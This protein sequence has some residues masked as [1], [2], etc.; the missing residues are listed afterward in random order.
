MGMEWYRLPIVVVSA[1]IMYLVFLV[2][3]R[4]FGARIL[5]VTSGFD[6]LVFIMLGAV[7]GRAIL[8]DPPTV[9]TGIVGLATLMIMEAI[10][11]AIERT[12]A[13]RKLLSGRPT[14]VFAHGAPL[15]EACRRT[16]TSQADLN[17]A[18]RGAGLASGADVLCIVLE[19]HGAYSVIKQGTTIDP[20]LFAHVDGAREH[21]LKG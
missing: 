11:G 10:F 5:T 19:P 15:D 9:A 18:I 8:G 7:A 16:H 14:L 20:A 12:W 3:V 17:A 13:S 2:L 21:L 6:A 4:I 1:V